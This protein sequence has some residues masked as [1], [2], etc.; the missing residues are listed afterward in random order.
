MTRAAALAY[1]LPRSSRTWSAVD[2]FGANGTDTIL[3]R[4][5]EHDLRLWHWANTEE[6]KNPDTAPDPIPLPG[7]ERAREAEAERRMAQAADV[8][9]RLGID[10]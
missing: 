3:L 8:A 9:A 7:E 1:Q 10:I 2:P 4:K 5:A 6:A